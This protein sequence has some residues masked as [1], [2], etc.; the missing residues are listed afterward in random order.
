MSGVLEGLKY[1]ALIGC[2]AGFIY[3]VANGLPLIKVEDDYFG[4]ILSCCSFGTIYAG[5]HGLPIGAIIGSKDKYIIVAPI[6]SSFAMRM[7]H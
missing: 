7:K 6:D 3:G 1:G 4:D 5:A 2:T